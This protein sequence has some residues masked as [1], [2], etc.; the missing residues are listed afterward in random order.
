MTPDKRRQPTFKAPKFFWTLFCTSVVLFCYL[1]EIKVS[2]DKERELEEMK[3]EHIEETYKQYM[4]YALKC[5]E[6][7]RSIYQASI[8]SISEVSESDSLSSDKFR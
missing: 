8:D 6:E 7:D 3:Q 2:I 1:D 5:Y 4:E